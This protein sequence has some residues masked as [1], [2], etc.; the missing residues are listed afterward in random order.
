MALPESR[1][2]IPDLEH[3]VAKAAR[4]VAVDPRA[5]P[6]FARLDEE[7]DLALR[8][9]SAR[10]IGDPLARARELVRIAR[11]EAA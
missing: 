4:I 11:R 3:A 5:L 8:A 10:K 2:S 7:L 6:I 9:Q 1:I